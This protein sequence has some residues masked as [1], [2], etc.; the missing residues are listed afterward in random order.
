MRRPRFCGYSSIVTQLNFFLLTEKRWGGGFLGPGV[1][2]YDF[3]LWEA[4]PIRLY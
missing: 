4:E 1:K 3:W 2:G